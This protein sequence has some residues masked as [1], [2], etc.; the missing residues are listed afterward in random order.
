MTPVSEP[1]VPTRAPERVVAAV[2][3][4]FDADL[5]LDRA[6]FRALLHE[7]D[8]HV[9]AVLVAGTTGEFVALDDDERLALCADALEVFG[10]GRTIGHVGTATRAGVDRLVD[11][12][13]DLGVER[14]ALLTPY[15]VPLDQAGLLAWFTAA[16]ARLSGRELYPYLFAE[17][18]GVTTEVATLAEVLA[19]D[20][21][22]GVK[23]SGAEARRLDRWVPAGRPGQSFWSGLDA[24]LDGT[25][26]QGG[27][28]IVSASSTAFPE[29]YGRLR[30]G[31][32]QPG[33]AERAEVDVQVEEAFAVTGPSLELLHGALAR[34]T[35]FPWATRL[36]APVATADQWA[37]LTRFM[38]AHAAPSAS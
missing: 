23:V 28:G 38:D 19:L 4:P 26:A 1:A 15:Y 8:P 29:L 33:T 20:G 9:D 27:T 37:R 30:D 18:T 6:A 24:G 25:L 21:V 14:L 34:R 35:G 31:G 10:P 2:P 11:G 36:P 32:D 13:L 22:A 3:T 7:L 5:R 16:A 17:R 12:A